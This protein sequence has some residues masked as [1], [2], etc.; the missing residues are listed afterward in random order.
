MFQRT[1][2]SKKGDL[3]SQSGV[4]CRGTN[5]KAQTKRGNEV[6]IPKSWCKIGKGAFKVR[7]ITRRGGSLQLLMPLKV[8][9]VDGIKGILKILID[10][11]AEANLIYK[12]LAPIRL[13]YQAEEPLTFLAANEG[14]IEGGDTCVDATLTFSQDVEGAF[15]E[16]LLEKTPFL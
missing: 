14:T 11:G 5:P 3:A 1:E 16:E 10:T 8:Q 13:V 6:K 2:K 12:G 9:F 7:K 4:G 15:L